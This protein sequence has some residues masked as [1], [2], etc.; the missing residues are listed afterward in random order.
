MPVKLVDQRRIEVADDGRAG[1]S[2][3]QNVIDEA[4]DGQRQDAIHVVPELEQAQDSLRAAIA[5]RQAIAEAVKEWIEVVVVHDEQSTARVAV[6][7]V[8]NVPGE[9]QSHRGFAG[10][11]FAKDERGRWLRRIAKD[12]IP[13][14]VVRAFDAEFFE[15]RVGLRIFLGK[16]IASDAVVIEELL[17][18]HAGGGFGSSTLDLRRSIHDGCAA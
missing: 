17:D 5:L 13:G 11:F 18:F 10:A 16:W 14:R 4:R 7:V 8:L 6:V 2:S 15:D 3:T 1:L 12:L 9:L